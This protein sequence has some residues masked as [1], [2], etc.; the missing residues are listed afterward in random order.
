MRRFWLLLLVFVLPLQMS[1]AAVHYCNDE[2]LLSTTVEAVMT[3]GHDHDGQSVKQKAEDQKSE[4][5]ADACCGA[6]HGCHGLHH[7]MPHT[8]ASL[9]S[10][11]RTGVTAA[12]D[13]PFPC[14]FLA[15]RVERP[16]W[17]AA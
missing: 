10:A 13:G 1:W 16:K 15:T 11:S 2:L 14:G 17:L 3:S 4:K 9:P 5:I 6:A 7:L 8:E 12:R